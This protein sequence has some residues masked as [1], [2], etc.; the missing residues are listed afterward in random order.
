LD[1]DEVEDICFENFNLSASDFKKLI[2][3]KDKI[4]NFV[5]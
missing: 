3:V 2:F 1:Q 5:G 4:I